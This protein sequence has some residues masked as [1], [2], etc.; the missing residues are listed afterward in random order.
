V[1]IGWRLR[2]VFRFF[3]DEQGYRSAVV[4]ENAK[5]DVAPTT[6]TS[7]TPV[8]GRLFS[9]ETDVERAA[10]WLHCTVAAKQIRENLRGVKREKVEIYHGDDG[11]SL[12]APDDRRRPAGYR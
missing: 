5:I 10:F 11:E 2:F 1:I 8:T 4:D 9:H 6:K 3:Y 7:D 12:F